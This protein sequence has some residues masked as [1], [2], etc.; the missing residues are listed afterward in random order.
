[1]AIILHSERLPDGCELLLV[2]TAARG[3]GAWAQPVRLAVVRTDGGE[4]THARCRAVQATLAVMRP[5]G[6]HR[7]PRSGYHRA[8][9]YLRGVLD[10]A[11]HTYKHGDDTPPNAVEVTAD[12]L[13]AARVA[14]AEMKKKK[15]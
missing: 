15:G 8:V 13:E 5:D 3:G 14:A 1:M 10:H 9:T 6:R 7:G 2:Q 4:Y 12:D 11:A